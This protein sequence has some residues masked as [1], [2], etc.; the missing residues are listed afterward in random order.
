MQQT[1]RSMSSLQRET[2]DIIQK[3][4]LHA[5]NIKEPSNLSKSSQKDAAK[6]PANLDPH[7]PTSGIL[8]KILADSLNGSQAIDATSNIEKTE[9]VKSSPSASAA[10]GPRSSEKSPSKG[11]QQKKADDEA[12]GDQSENHYLD[13]KDIEVELDLNESVEDNRDQEQTEKINEENDIQMEQLVERI[14]KQV[15]SALLDTEIQY[16]LNDVLKRDKSKEIVEDEKLPKVEDESQ[17]DQSQKEESSPENDEKLKDEIDVL[18]NILSKETRSKQIDKDEQKSS[19]DLSDQQ[20]QN[21]DAKS[22][23]EEEEKP[24]SQES[25]PQAKSPKAA[26]LQQSDIMPA[27]ISLKQAQIQQELD[28]LQQ[29]QKKEQQQQQLIAGIDT[30]IDTVESYIED[31]FTQIRERGPQFLNAFLTPIYKDPLEHLS[32]LQKA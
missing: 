17:I 24:Q 20:T 25:R 28:E 5:K 18:K 8:E 12:E 4:N 15:I 30:S 23:K 1:I 9:S 7:P 10:G 21:K 16:L 19:K 32:L 13:E 11:S 27:Q 6:S 26:A 2:M 29:L 14:Q 31:I 3:V 22:G